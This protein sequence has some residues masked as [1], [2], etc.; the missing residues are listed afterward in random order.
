MYLDNHWTWLQVELRAVVEEV[1]AQNLLL[2]FGGQTDVVSA[3]VQA[4]EEAVAAWD[5][6]QHSES[7]KEGTV[8]VWDKHR[9]SDAIVVVLV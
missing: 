4:A 8:I 6:H 2:L 5:R 9:N 3:M 7:E 1:D